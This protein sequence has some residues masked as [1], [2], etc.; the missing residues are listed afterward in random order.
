MRAPKEIEPKPKASERKPPPDAQ[1]SMEGTVVPAILDLQ[2]TAGNRAVNAMVQRDGVRQ[3]SRPATRGR[4]EAGRPKPAPHIEV[5]SFGTQILRGPAG[6]GH[7]LDMAPGAAIKLVKGDTAVLSVTF[8]GPAKEGGSGGL[9]LRT[10][11]DGMDV[12]QGWKTDRRFEWEITFTAVGTHRAFM[13]AGDPVMEEAEEFNIV[14]EGDEVIPTQPMLEQQATVWIEQ[15]WGALNQGLADFERNSQVSSWHALALGVLGNLIWAAAAFTTGE[16]AFLISIEGI[17]TGTVGSIAGIN[18]QED[19]H[20]VARGESDALEKALKARVPKVVDEVHGKATADRWGGRQTYRA[21]IERLLKPDFVDEG[22]IASV[23]SPR[24][25]A[26]TERELFLRSGSSP[27]EDWAGWK[28][29]DWWIEYRYRVEGAL[30]PMHRAA[31]FDQWR[32][33]SAPE[34]ATLYPI[35]PAVRNA[36]DRLNELQRSLGGPHRVRDWP[37]RKLLKLE[38]LGSYALTVWLDG[39]NRAQGLGSE[40]LDRRSVEELLKAAGWDWSGHGLRRY[41]WGPSGLPADIDKI[42]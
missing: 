31:P 20:K 12:K 33:E 13:R 36:R 21:L 11:G 4:G 23:N 24:I 18:S 2:R 34:A 39:N 8:S 27:S 38:V 17:A 41:V 9:E 37:L 6:K 40:Y 28:H 32:L 26:L 42:D 22:P 19:F 30:D 10:T 14:A 25:A 29:G 7:T 1:D 5:E 15:V 16:M 3:R 35:D